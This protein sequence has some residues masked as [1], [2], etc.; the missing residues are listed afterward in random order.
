MAAVAEGFPA[1]RNS[2]VILP[3]GSEVGTMGENHGAPRREVPYKGREASH[4]IL[5]VD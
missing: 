5:F 1:L 2:L 4:A 3:T